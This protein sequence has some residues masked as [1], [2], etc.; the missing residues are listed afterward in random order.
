MPAWN[1]FSFA[2]GPLVAVGLVGLFVL[3]LRWAFRRGSSVVA[4]APRPGPSDAYGLMV[5]VAS[6]AT[7][8]DG[9]VVRRQ[10]EEHGLR[11]NLAQ[12]LD[13]PR[14]MVWPADEAA[15]RSVLSRLG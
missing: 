6:P 1:S 10:L 15:A 4:A 5:P 11:A 14:V 12:T 13:G 7:Y 8:I 9:E 3:I 2:F